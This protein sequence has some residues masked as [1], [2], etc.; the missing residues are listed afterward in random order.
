MTEK[1]VGTEHHINWFTQGAHRI[2]SINIPRDF[3]EELVKALEALGHKPLPYGRAYGQP[4]M[5]LIDYA[6]GIY[7][8]A[9]DAA[10]R[11]NV[12]GYCSEENKYDNRREQHG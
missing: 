10:A 1:R 9:G 7:W 12:T 5:V 4:S 6:K 8:G 11:R 3:D 2:G